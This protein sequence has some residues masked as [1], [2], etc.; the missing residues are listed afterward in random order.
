MRLLYWLD[1]KLDALLVGVGSW[2]LRKP[3]RPLIVWVGT[4]TLIALGA[5]GVLEFLEALT[6]R[7]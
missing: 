2:A 6:G 4:C 7:Q 1:Y 5:T 3:H